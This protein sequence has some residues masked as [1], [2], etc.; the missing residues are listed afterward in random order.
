MLFFSLILLNYW[1]L[2]NEGG[3]FN[4]LE[5]EDINWFDEDGEDYTQKYQGE[6]IT[7]NVM[8]DGVLYDHEMYKNRGIKEQFLNIFTG[9]Q[10]SN[11]N[12]PKNNWIGTG[13]VGVAAGDEYSKCQSTG[14][15]KKANVASYY[16]TSYSGILEN[17]QYVLCKNADQWNI[18]LLQYQMTNCQDRFCRYI[19]PEVLPH[20]LLNDCLYEPKNGIKPRPFVISSGSDHTSDPHFSPP[21][22]WPLMFAIAGV[23]NRGYP[24]NHGAE[25]VGVFMCAPSA[26]Y[27]AIP[28]SSPLGTTS[29]LTNYTTPNASAAI[30]AGGLAVLMSANPDL[31]LADLFFVTAMT[32][33]QTFPG[34]Q[35][36][37]S[38]AFGLNYSRR[39]G[40]GRLNLKQAVKLVT[41]QNDPWES[42]GDFYLWKEEKI[43]LNLVLEKGEYTVEFTCD[44]PEAE[45]V[46]DVRLTLKSRKLSFGSLNPH[47]LSPQGTNSELKI[48][49]EGDRTL[50][51]RS[52]EF[53]TRKHLGEDP[54]G[55]WKLIFK[56]TDD[57]NRGFIQDASLFIYYVKKRPDPKK[58][59]KR[60]GQNPFK[61]TDP[62][63]RV[64]FNVDP[65]V[66]YP[67]VAGEPW[68]VAVTVNDESIKG[69]DYLCYLED[70]NGIDR[71]KIKAYYNADYTKV[72]LAYSP[73]VFKDGLPMKFVIDSQEPNYGYTIKLN[74]QYTNN[75]EPGIIIPKNG[76]IISS[77]QKS[78]DIQYALNLTKI[79]DDGY[80][81]SAALTILSSTSRTILDR[82]FRRNLGKETYDDAVPS[83]RSFY[84]QIS[85]SSSDRVEQFDPMTI[86]LH[87]KET[88]GPY[89]P[90]K[91]KFTLV[92]LIFLIIFFVIL[93]VFSLYRALALY[94]TKSK[95]QA[96]DETG[97]LDVE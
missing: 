82:S 44:E 62:G 3:S 26:D 1:W 45:A 88:P 31:T 67:M 51:I 18:S 87:V 19:E 40:F 83:D 71:V 32:G 66:L 68:E 74:L 80:S 55:T 91:S 20:T 64:K 57:A 49:S 58:I 70:Q 73:S 9:K 52:M 33:D 93:I 53:P 56:E 84:F 43:S 25:G 78:L 65:D 85:P 8:S 95:P 39:A 61:E 86:L 97:L 48:I 63:D 89:N 41:D 11:V 96:A 42:V 60:I 79:C 14:I 4:A 50:D 22:R 46:L 27:A 7:I 54:R 36:W 34:S 37:E 35:T 16:F 69:K 29:C 30:F 72:T 92:L 6:G 23:N 47:L 77:N 90:L 76:E 38:N 24:L 75:Y 2:H 81:T 28:T 17:P 21:G 5:G 59:I 12:D 94:F 15:A 13:S 10:M